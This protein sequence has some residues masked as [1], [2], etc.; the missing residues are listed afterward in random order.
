MTSGVNELEKCAYCRW[1]RDCED[2]DEDIEDCE[3]FELDENAC[4]L[5]ALD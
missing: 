3:N 1:L 5:V 2:V 4:K